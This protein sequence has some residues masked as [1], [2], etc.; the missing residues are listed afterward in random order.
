MYT[1]VAVTEQHE[2]EVV[3]T[4]DKGKHSKTSADGQSLLG[5]RCDLAVEDAIALFIPCSQSVVVS[6]CDLRF[7]SS[8]CSLTGM[9]KIKV[10]GCGNCVCCGVDESEWLWKLSVSVW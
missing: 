6:S 2:G 4:S 7:L 9:R 5:Q 10:N 8:R 3:F 1:A